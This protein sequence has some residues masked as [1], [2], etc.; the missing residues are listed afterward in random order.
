MPLYDV[1]LTFYVKGTKPND[2]V[3]DFLKAAPHLWK[4]LYHTQVV[5]TVINVS[6]PTETDLIVRLDTSSL[7]LLEEWVLSMKQST[8]VI[9]RAWNMYTACKDIPNSGIAPIGLLMCRIDD[10]MSKI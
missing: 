2:N 1:N 7:R 10:V 9:Y 8:E 3:A 5:F 6:Q 4:Q